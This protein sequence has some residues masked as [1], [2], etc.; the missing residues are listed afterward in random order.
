MK[1][2]AYQAP[3]SGAGPREAVERIEAQ[4]RRC[5][6][7]GVAVLCCPEAVLG[8]LADHAPHPGAFALAADPAGLGAILAPLASATVAVIV[9]FSERGGDGRLYN[10]AAVLHRGE[11][12][13]VYRKRHPAI[14]RSVYSAGREAPVFRV[15]PLV[16]ALAICN[17]SN[18]PEIAREAAARGAAALFVPTN[19]GMPPSKAGPGLAERTRALDRATARENGLWV[20]RADVAGRLGALE[21]EGCS[22]ITDP[23]GGAAARAG[24]WK[25][26]LIVAEIGALAGLP[27]A[28]PAS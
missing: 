22:A 8:G 3:L 14:R 7:E 26:D 19:N 24:A 9:G 21:C 15:G 2:A 17:D 1:V 27:G 16:F 25:E 11:I 13:G 23:A 4:V 10:S 12:V 18:H 28:G 6:R 20:V 5:E